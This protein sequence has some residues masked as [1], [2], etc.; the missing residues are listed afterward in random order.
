M[1][2]KG[3]ADFKNTIFSILRKQIK[4]FTALQVIFSNHVFLLD[5]EC[6]GI[7]DY[8]IFDL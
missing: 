4:L 2:R 7:H 1:S 8:G 6:L 3:P 5:K